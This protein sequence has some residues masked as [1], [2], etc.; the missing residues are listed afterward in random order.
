[1][2]GLRVPHLVSPRELPDGSVSWEEQRPE[3][4]AR[5]RDGDGEFGWLGD[6]RLSLV[7]NKTYEDPHGRPRWEVWRRHEDGSSSLVVHK[8]GFRINGDEL[9]EQLA[10][11]DSRTHDVAG[12][13]LARRVKAKRDKERRFREHSEEKADKLAWALGR[14]LS[15]PAQPGRVFPVS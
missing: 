10:L 5:I 2:A 6:D 3:L 1:M 12:E 9:I 14:D 7:L 8:V 15:V 4:G 11:H 13:V